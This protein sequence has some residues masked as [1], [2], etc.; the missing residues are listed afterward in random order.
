MFIN[1]RYFIVLAEEGSI[2]GAAK[3][4][5]ITHQALCRY[6][7]NLEE[8]LN[9]TLFERKPSLRLTDAGRMVYE[10]L[11]QA[12]SLEQNLR[13]RLADYNNDVTGEIRLGTT[14]GRFRIL[15][16][17]I[18]EEYKK[19]FPLVSLYTQSAKSTWLHKMLAAGELDA[20]ILNYSPGL[21]KQFDVET[22]LEENL[23][24]VIS[25]S[26]M[27][28]YF[29]DKAGE[30][31]EMFK[32]GADLRLMTGV[33]FAL[34]LPT[35]NSSIMIS[36]VLHRLGISLNCIHVSS[37]P[38]LHHALSAKNLAASLCLT[39]YLP[40]VFRLNKEEKE[41]LNIF[42]ILGLNST[43]KVVMARVK[44]RIFTHY[45]SALLEIIRKRSRDFKKY[46]AY[47]EG[48]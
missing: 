46:D 22:I 24:L 31:A 41:H 19:T 11:K 47:I 1:Y 27:K 12:G 7:A 17:D 33:P 3:R 2:S 44:N 36:D 37:H 29:G 34:N 16:P 42:P 26:M 32:S 9:V 23:Y 30:Y 39:M 38:D 21:E 20:A 10:T 5:Y 14:E 45:G 40:S 25:D 13:S 28:T 18:I 4:L 48:G 15:L 43:N 8:E 35:F 6:L